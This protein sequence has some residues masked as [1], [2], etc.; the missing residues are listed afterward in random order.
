[1]TDSGC[2]DTRSTGTCS[3]HTSGIV[4]DF[5]MSPNRKQPS[6]FDC[7]NCSNV[8]SATYSLAR[9]SD[10]LLSN[11]HLYS[12]DGF[13][14]LPHC[15]CHAE[16]NSLLGTKSTVSSTLCP[17][18]RLSRASS[19]DN[20]CSAGD[21]VID[22]PIDV[23]HS[24]PQLSQTSMSKHLDDSKRNSGA[25]TLFNLKKQRGPDPPTNLFVY[26]DTTGEHNMLVLEWTP[27]RYIW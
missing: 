25:H 6:S 3:S 1:M 23:Y 8:S 18:I 9:D 13:H 20:T 5:P 11:L 16:A 21:T 10:V 19:T 24:K 26:L 2:D 15:T 22:E 17:S 7:P 14:T 4:T 27:V 12:D